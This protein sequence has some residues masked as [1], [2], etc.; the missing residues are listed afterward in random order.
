MWRGNVKLLRCGQMSLFSLQWAFFSKEWGQVVWE[1]LRSI[2]PNDVPCIFWVLICCL[3]DVHEENLC[4]C[5]DEEHCEAVLQATEEKPLQSTPLV[6]QG[7]KHCWL[8]FCSQ[9]AFFLPG[10]PGWGCSSMDLKL[11]A[12]C[13]HWVP[14]DSTSSTECITARWAERMKYMRAVPWSLYPW[15]RG[16]DGAYA[17][18]HRQWAAARERL[19]PSCTEVLV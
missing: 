9:H 17:L 4:S 6:Q 3:T 18:S 13:C 14:L 1:R 2:K 10:Y 16:R 19:K 12:N 8:A 7:F 5:T 11:Q 15:W